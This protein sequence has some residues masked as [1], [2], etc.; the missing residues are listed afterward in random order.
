[1]ERGYSE[2]KIPVVFL[3][4]SLLL[5]Y[6]LTAALLLLLAFFLYKP[7]LTESIV[8][9]AIIGIYVLS[10]FFAGFITGKKM[11]TKKYIWGFLMGGAYFLVLLL[12]SLFVNRSLGDFGN[13]FLTTLA[14]CTGGGMMGGMVS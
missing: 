7:G 13:S 4:K 6:I 5:S 14:L 8:S 1:M 10:T 9:I 2:G 11:R 3:L 12:I